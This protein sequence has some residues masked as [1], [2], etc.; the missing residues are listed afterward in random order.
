MSRVGKTTRTAV[1]RTERNN[2]EAPHSVFPDKR[3][4]DVYRPTRP[5]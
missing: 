2:T 1:R 3:R 4:T 5:S